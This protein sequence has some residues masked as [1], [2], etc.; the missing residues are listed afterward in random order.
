MPLNVAVKFLEEGIGKHRAEMKRRG[1]SLK[2]R[3]RGI[4]SLRSESDQE[5]DRIIARIR[6]G[7]SRMRA[8]IDRDED[9]LCRKISEIK[10]NS[11]AMFE[12][13]LQDIETNVDRFNLLE[14]LHSKLSE[15][16]CNTAKAVSAFGFIMANDLTAGAHRTDSVLSQLHSHLPYNWLFKPNSGNRA[17]L[18]ELSN[19]KTNIFGEVCRRRT[20]EEFASLDVP[21]E[22]QAQVTGI[23]INHGGSIPPCI[24]QDEQIAI[25]DR[26]TGVISL[27]G[28]GGHINHIHD[29]RV[30]AVAHNAPTEIQDIAFRQNGNLLV[31][32]FP[33]GLI[34][35]ITV[36]GKITKQF[37]LS[38]PK[39]TWN[40]LGICINRRNEV[41]ITFIGTC[42]VSSKKAFAIHTMDWDT[43]KVTKSRS[44]D[45]SPRYICPLDDGGYAVSDYISHSVYFLNANLKPRFVYP[46]SAGLKCPSG[47]CCLPNGNVLIVDK[48]NCTVHEVSPSGNYKRVVLT[49]RD[50]LRL[51]KS[52]ACTKS[53][54]VII[55]GERGDLIKAYRYHSMGRLK[56]S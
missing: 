34:Y 52:V 49:E 10:D 56:I 44:L 15:S 12:A 27:Y 25:S 5:V 35:E 51:P 54:D 43:L 19:K 3:V 53:G 14:V 47:L 22:N 45:F 9:E 26:Y 32:N 42:S 37:S 4:E 24:N 50:G 30:P 48:E 55:A 46:G 18:E 36:T 33:V 23:D 1:E 17:F 20:L 6:E 8:I 41:A 16:E 11:A 40:P 38:L 31:T 2:V 29:I 28:V 21:S 39:S 7:A 13:V